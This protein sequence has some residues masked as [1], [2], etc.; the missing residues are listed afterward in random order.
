MSGRKRIWLFILLICSVFTLFFI[1]SDKIFPAD[2][3]HLILITT[4]ITLAFCILFVEHFFTK[5][6]DVLASTIAILLTLSPLN[7]QL[8]KM[9]IWYDLFY[10]YNLVL[11]FSSF[12]ALYLLDPDK[13]ESSIENFISLN[14]KRFS[15]H[16]GNARV[17]YGGLFI[18]TMFFYIDSQSSEFVA[19]FLFSAV[20]LFCD[21]KKFLDDVSFK[22]IKI[23]N[24]IGEII[25]VQSGNIFIA[26]LFTKRVSIKKFD[27]VQFK[28]LRGSEESIT[29]GMI[30]DNYLLNQEQWVK[31]LCNSEIQQ[32]LETF[33]EDGIRKANTLYKIEIGTQCPELLNRFV[34]IVIEG[35]TIQKL[36][37]EYGQHSQSQA[38]TE[39][40]LLTVTTRA[41][42][43]LY[44]VVQGITEIETLESKNENGFIV[45][46]AVQLGVWN[47]TS[48]TFEKFGWLPA[49]N[50]PVYIAPSISPV[51]VAV[52]EVIVGKIPNTNYPSILRKIDAVT[53]HTAILGVTGTGK[54]VFTRKLI[55]EIVCSSTK[56]IVVDFTGEHKDKL[57]DLAPSQII[58]SGTALSEYERLVRDFLSSTQTIAML[59]IPDMTNT[60]QM[61]NAIKCFFE[62]LFIVAK[63]NKA[64]GVDQKICI[65]LEEAHTIIPEWQFIS[66]DKNYQQIVNSI[67]QIALQGRKYNIGFIVI[68]QRTANV[69]KTV[70][71]QCNTII[72]FKQFDNT[73]S[74]FLSNYLG[75]DMVKALPNLEDRTAIAVGKAFKANIPMIFRVP[76]I[77]E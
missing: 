60:Q 10:L 61:F 9:G 16:F 67:A 69:A 66:G 24:D 26:K 57:S 27:F 56:V 74:E 62:K 55:R 2:Q 37:F 6:A 29:K 72:A 4:L 12:T 45:G 15:V 40:S 65:V 50:S 8:D 58:P 32:S 11:L 33:S 64:S 48:T 71:T 52:D 38:I 43:V 17:L 20:I 19:L 51:T 21:P 13:S 59:E 77:I 70:L 63:A 34:G 5:P 30:V 47:S 36:R 73:S 44:Q 25:G 39:G 42:S 54:S 28:Y 49:I 23:G 41:Q 75:H 31:V 46:E 14:L 3:T 35:S 68:A 18:L 76:D 1:S 22:R 7:G 53:H